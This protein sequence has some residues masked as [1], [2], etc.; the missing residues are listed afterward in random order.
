[1]AKST[2]P[3]RWFDSSPEVIRTVV[4]TY[5]KY[6]LS[7]RSVEGACQV[8]FAQLEAPYPPNVQATATAHAAPASARRRRRAGLLIR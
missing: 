5:V 8:N 2:N 1:M 3:F 6:P 4:M 7:L